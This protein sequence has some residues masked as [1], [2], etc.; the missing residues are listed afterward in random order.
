MASRSRSLWDLSC[1]SAFSSSGWVSF[2]KVSSTANCHEIASQ[3]ARKPGGSRR[4]PLDEIGQIAVHRGRNQSECVKPQ[5]FTVTVYE[6]AS[7]AFYVLLAGRF[8][9]APECKPRDMWQVVV[10]QM[11]VIVEE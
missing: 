4:V 11:I 2:M 10:N 6:K 7:R 3:F 1:G 8:I 9:D 5:P